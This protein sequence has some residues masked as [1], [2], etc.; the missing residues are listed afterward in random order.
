MHHFVHFHLNTYH[1][2]Y[3]HL[4]AYDVVHFLVCCPIG[5]FLTFHLHCNSMITTRMFENKQYY[6]IRV[7]Y[8]EILKHTKKK[9]LLYGYK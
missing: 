2:I 1:A 9:S 3:F 5:L 6:K 8:G 7:N 4:N